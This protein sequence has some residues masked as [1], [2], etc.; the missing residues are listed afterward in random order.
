MASHQSCFLSVSCR[1]CAR[2]FLCAQ[3]CNRGIVHCWS[4]P[5]PMPR[6]SSQLTKPC[7]TSNLHHGQKNS[8]LHTSTRTPRTQRLIPPSSQPS[9]HTCLPDLTSSPVAVR[10][11]RFTSPRTRFPYVTPWRHAVFPAR[12]DNNLDPIR[13][14][15]FHNIHIK[16]SHEPPT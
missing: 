4:L 5:G 16:K 3:L 13:F 9:T 14:L 15:H 11:V 7:G 6:S 10:Q 8:G 12:V 1:C 2:C